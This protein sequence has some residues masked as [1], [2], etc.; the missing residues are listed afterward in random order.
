MYQKAF[1]ENSV[2]RKVFF[3]F[4]LMFSFKD[5]VAK[6]KGLTTPPRTTEEKGH[7]LGVKITMSFELI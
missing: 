1:E 4:P 6:I 7:Y 3:D 5:I 2:L